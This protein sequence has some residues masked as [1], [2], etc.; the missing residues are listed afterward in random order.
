MS[1]HVFGTILT[2]RSVAANNRGENEGNAT[3]LQKVVR[4]GALYS[5]VSG[6]AVRYALREVWSEDDDLE[7]NRVVSHRGSEWRDSEFKKGW[8]KYIDNDVRYMHA[9]KETESR[10]GVLEMSRAVSTTPWPGTVCANFASPGANPS[11]THGNPI[12]Y[13]AE[14]H[15]TRYQYTFAM[16]P[17]S[18][19][20]KDKVARLEKS[21]RGIESAPCRQPFAVSLRFRTGSHRPS[22]DA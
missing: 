2:A 3:T 19:A 6:E 14:M 1:L 11:V 5:T 20:G 10:R 7:L 4:D 17:G 22:S 15:D 16:T 21:L 18:F 8:E 13:A 9:K 12:P